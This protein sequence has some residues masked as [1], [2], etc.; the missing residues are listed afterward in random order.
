MG[1]ERKTFGQLRRESQNRATSFSENQQM[2]ELELFP[3]TS[4]HSYNGGL[5]EGDTSRDQYYIPAVFT[6]QARQDVSLANEAVIVAERPCVDGPRVVV[7]QR[8]GRVRDF[9]V[10]LG[11]YDFTVQRFRCKKRNG[12]ILRVSF[13]TA[14]ERRHIWIRREALQGRKLFKTLV[15]E[16]IKMN[17]ALSERVLYEALNGFINEKAAE[18]QPRYVPYRGGWTREAGGW[19][20][21]NKERCWRSLEMRCSR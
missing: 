13:T 5:L 3:V 15:G 1:G 20:W 7:Q 6:A 9:L 11:A 18:T 14:G 19:R 8:N 10:L 16:G 17:F 21:W 2:P 4:E 12:E